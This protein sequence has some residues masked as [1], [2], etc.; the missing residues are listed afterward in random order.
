MATATKRTSSFGNGSKAKAA[1][2][3]RKATALPVWTV[4][5]AS[6]GNPTDLSRWV[7][8]FLNSLPPERAASAKVSAA[9]L[10]NAGNTV[11]HWIYITYLA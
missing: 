3:P 2:P 5:Y 1:A 8:N 7:S 4:A 9:G 10:N 11:S 6:F